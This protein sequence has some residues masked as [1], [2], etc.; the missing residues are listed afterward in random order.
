[1][2]IV[3]VIL[4]LLVIVVGIFLLN[5]L[6]PER[7]AARSVATALVIAGVVGIVFLLVP[8]AARLF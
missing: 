4:F 5:A 7:I 6:R 3:P 2:P 1:M 8:A